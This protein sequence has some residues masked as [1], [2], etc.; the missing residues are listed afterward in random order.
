MKHV[1]I[2]HAGPDKEFADRLAGDLKNAGHETV[3][4]TKELKL[5]DNAISFMNDGITN[6]RTVI[7]LYSKHTPKADWQD[8]EIN[9]AVWNE[10]AQEGGTCIVVRLDATPVPPILGPKVYGSFDPAETCSYR[11][12][13]DDLCAAILPGKT[14]LS[15]LAD[16]FRTESGNPFRRVRAEY[17]EDRPDLFPKAFAAPDATKTG[18]LEDMKPCFLEGS[19]G[20]GKSMLLLSLRGRNFLARNKGSVDAFKV[21]GFY[22]K[23]TRGALCNA[24]L[25]PTSEGEPEMLSAQERAQVIDISSQEF[26]VC[27]MESLFSEINYCAKGGLLSLDPIME[28]QLT[29]SAWS[30][31]FDENSHQPESLDAL[32]GRLANTHRS[33]AEFVRRRY[34][35]GEQRPVPVATFD[36]EAIKRI[37]GLVRRH[38]DVLRNTMFVALLDE[39]ENLFRYQ[40]RIVNGFVKL[41]SPDMSVKVAKKLGTGDVSGTTTGQELQ[42]TH[43]YARLVLVY[44]VEDS[45]QYRAYCELLKHI[46][47]N[48]LK[49]EGRG[50]TDLTQLLPKY[51]V[52]EVPSEDLE[53][54][55]AKL[56][57]VS[58]E[59]FRNWPKNKRAD[60]LTYYGHAGI[61]R[62]LYGHKGPHRD[63]RFSGFDDLSFLSSGVIR[64]FQE[65]LGVAYHLSSDSRTLTKGPLSFSPEHQSK[66]VYYV[67]EHN[68]TTL[69]RNVES[70]GETLKYFILD[71]GDCLRHKLLRDTS[72]P[73]A[74]RLTFIDPECLQKSEMECLKD[75]IR[76]GEREGVF[77]TKEGRPAYR[78]KHASD[79]QPSELKICRIFAPV[80]QI[81]PRLRW[82]TEVRCEQLL[83]LV[84]PTRRAQ[85]LQELKLDMVKPRPPKN[86]M[87]IEWNSGGQ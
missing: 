32:L 59:E 60:K 69:S 20:T 78:P 10:I 23:L 8:L 83:G 6:A 66:A 80:L 68:L 28:R 48:L 50:E 63:K 41:A 11:K 36:L 35:Y 43:D 14:A 18:A 49:G 76:V 9:S 19:R 51:L 25:S 84:T 4:D 17:F 12:L 33:I 72:E 16:A 7:I 74:A 67:S 53:K 46:V 81:S 61:Y 34:I 62:I 64:Y 26:V 42:E 70:L 85:A 44:D 47:V 77:Q 52:P 38:V 75:L 55:V 58:V 24:G 21:F 79:P 15:V 5:G 57:K 27:L 13:L 22:L 39:Y 1:F 65:I 30:A 31:L 56:C 37:I 45:D 3:I 87:E 29:Q 40:Q 73:E 71:V 54:E 86:Q 82:R 2:S